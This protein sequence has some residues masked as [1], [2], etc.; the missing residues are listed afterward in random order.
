MLSEHGPVVLLLLATAVFYAWNITVNQM[1]NSFYAASAW[2]GS[3]SWE[4]LLFGSLDPGNSI[5]VDKPPVSQ[6][7]MGLSGKIFG[8][9]SASM[10]LPQVLM[11]VVSVG[12]LYGAVRRVAGRGAGLIAGSLLA[13][14]PVAALMF[15]YNNPDGAMVTLM[16]LGAYCTV[17]AV[18]GRGGRWLALAG[19]ALGFAFL[20]KMLEGLMVLPALGLAY[21]IAAPV[22]VGKRIQHLLGAAAALVVSAGWYVVLTMLWP[23]DSR[24][25]MAGS[26][27]NSFMN[28]VFGYNG[29]GRLLGSHNGGGGWGSRPADCP[30]PEFIEQMRER[31]AHHHGGFGPFGA[32]P[33]LSRLFTGEWGLEIGF[34]VPVALVAFVLALVSRGRAPR[35]D[36]MRV[37]VLVFGVWML[38]D[39]L[40]LAEMKRA[41]SYYSL[42]MAPA[43]AATLA[44]GVVEMW[45]RRDRWTGRAG[46]ALLIAIGGGWGFV[47]LSRDTSF[48]PAMRW[49]V[50]VATVAAVVA[51][52][53][54]GERVAGV[55]TRTALTVV[56]LA[57]AAVAVVGGSAS[58]A[59]AAVANSHAGPG[60]TLRPVSGFGGFG[61][62]TPNDDVDT[63]LSKTDTHWSAAVNGSM[64]A[65]TLELNTHTSLIAVGGFTGQDPSPNLTQFQGYVRAREVRYFIV[66]P[67]RWGGGAASDP[68]SDQPDQ[69]ETNPA[70]NTGW[71]SGNAATDQVTA[72]VQKYF[73]P[74]T[75]GGMT[76]YDLANPP[77][78]AFGGR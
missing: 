30:V 35:T 57:L 10:L 32:Q 67:N 68:A 74:V 50:L 61:F 5:T 33:G 48:A 26:T 46:L 44:L 16:I 65:A 70:C 20:A 8:F 27:D 43:V 60:L 25:Y 13:L 39:G 7:V 56:G 22:T 11:G 19:V 59:V 73:T 15:R 34:L 21:L 66:A 18:Q 64:Q 40:V 28:L 63:L 17:R 53:V 4:A 14:T 76:V 54:P 1:G 55:R 31:L 38:V 78:A 24:P 69:A 23:V 36:L 62:N 47:L 29:F 51:A 6:W 42:S 75:V 52:L 12:L 2:A 45:R 72:W 9:S 71:G 37:G 41:A 49:I 77:A 3:R 58:Y